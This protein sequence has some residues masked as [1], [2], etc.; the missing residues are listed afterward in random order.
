MKSQVISTLLASLYLL[1]SS[2]ASNLKTNTFC[3]SENRRCNTSL[4]GSCVECQ[5]LMWFVNRTQTI[6]N[7][8]KIIFLP[9]NHNLKSF[10]QEKSFLIFFNKHNLKLKGSIVPS[11]HDSALCSRVVCS[12]QTGFKFKFSSNILIQGLGFEGCGIASL[13]ATLNFYNSTNITLFH[14]SI[15][16]SIGQSL[17]ILKVCRGYVNITESIFIRCIHSSCKYADN[18]EIWFDNCTANDLASTSLMLASSTLSFGRCGSKLQGKGLCLHIQQPLVKV[19]VVNVTI[20]NGTAKFGGNVNIQLESDSSVVKFINS[21]IVNGSAKY[22]GGIYIYLISGT[23]NCNLSNNNESVTEMLFINTKFEENNASISNSSGGGIY[24]NHTGQ[25]ELCYVPSNITLISCAFRRNYAKVAV[26]ILISQLNL[27]SYLRHSEPQLI[28]SMDNCTFSENYLLDFEEQTNGD[29]IVDLYTTTSVTVRN[30]VFA[31]NNGTALLLMDSTVLFEGEISFLNNTAAYGGAIRVCEN[32]VIY[33]KE[34]QVLFKDNTAIVAG[35]AIYAGERCLQ[36][37]PR[38]FYQ[39]IS[40]S[41]LEQISKEISL[42]F[43]NNTASLAGGAIYGGS[44]DN[45]FTVNKVNRHY[46]FTSNTDDLFRAIFHIHPN[47]SSMVT[48]D[49]YG[50]CICDPVTGEPNCSSHNLSLSDK[51]PGETLVIHVTAVGQTNGPVPAMVNVSKTHHN[52]T[53]IVHKHCENQITKCQTILLTLFAKPDTNETLIVSVFQANPVKVHSNY[54][55]MPKLKARLKMAS[56]PWVFQLNKTNGC[57]CHEIIKNM[58]KVIQCDIDTV[59]IQVPEC[60]WFNCIDGN[61]SCKQIEGSS[62][63]RHGTEKWRTFTQFNISDQC[64]RGW[65][66][67][68]CGHCASNYSLSL[69]FPTCVKNEEHCSVWKLILLLFVFFLSGILLVCFLAV[70]NLTVAEGT[71][72]GILFYANCIHANQDIFFHTEHKSSTTTFFRV[73]IAW[74][75]LDLGFQ[76]CLY[77]GMTAYQKFWLECGF[78]LYLLLI[79]VVI[80]CLSHKFIWFTRLIGRNV[81]PVL[82]TVLLLAY[83]K[84]VRRSIKGFHCT[85]NNYW[86]TEKNIPLMW[87][88]DETID[89]FL[90]KHIPLFVVSLLVFIVATLYAVSLL[91]IQCLQRGSGW[92]VLRWVNKLRPFF[93]ANTGQCR[94]HYRFWPGLL[95]LIKFGVLVES[96]VVITEK[97]RI[98]ILTAVSVFM[99]FWC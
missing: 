3:V 45:C 67:R 57:D 35:G 23:F 48:S 97:D 63:N 24:L 87:Y 14:V 7:D 39:P 69:G 49:P 71:I 6:P 54:Y 79:G 60:V 93:D 8:S 11:N 91:M 59:S 12:G 68:L 90:G 34:T 58:S 99:F 70:F 86:S 2:K 1:L 76:V 50:V 4:N 89:C 94:D 37:H 21:H 78:L 31:N 56:C 17:Y 84:L 95:H 36:K 9:G 30:S 32:S 10:G 22:G 28:I 18:V 73:F 19:S 27:P 80:V 43:I 46:V 96:A 29:G 85:N 33:L 55:R 16:D 44:V 42:R 75:N 83:P 62:N 61:Y 65:G 13:E 38:C 88:E 47:S 5:P 82:S 74:L 92:F 51:Y 53:I 66:G 40:N 26:A 52:S 77:N 41:S 64:K 81:V 25:V 98:S 15:T 72:T 20:A